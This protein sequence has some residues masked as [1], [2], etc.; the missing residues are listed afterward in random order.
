MPLKGEGWSSWCNGC[1]GR[2]WGDKI[3]VPEGAGS[4]GVMLWG[5]ALG[6][7]EEKDQ[8]PFRPYAQAGSLLE[9]AIRLAGFTRQQFTL[10][11]AIM[12]RPPGNKL[13][14]QP[15]EHEVTERCLHYNGRLVG[16][17]KPR[18]ILALGAVATRLLTEFDGSTKQRSISTVRGWAV[19]SRQFDR[20]GSTL[21]FMGDSDPMPVIPTLH[22]SYIQ[23][24]AKSLL[25][26]L[27]HD[28]R[29][30]VHIARQGVGVPAPTT[31]LLNPS[32]ED[33][34]S[35][36]QE[37]KSNPTRL[38]SYDIET[39]WSQSHE[40]DDD[41]E[42]GDSA[43]TT[44][45]FSLGAH[46]G[47]ELPWAGRYIEIASEI[48][49]TP[50]PKL[51][52]N[53]WQYDE[54]RL[55]SQGCNIRGVHHDLRWAFH[56]LYPDIPTNLQFICSFLSTQMRVLTVNS[57]NRDAAA[58]RPWKHTSQM[59]GTDYGCRDVDMP[60]R[61]FALVEAELKRLGA[62]RSYEEHT[63][64]F[65]PILVRASDYGVPVNP[66]LHA[67]FD[68]SLKAELAIK[69]AELQGLVPDELKMIEPKQGYKNPK[70]ALKR[71]A[72]DNQG[73]AEGERWIEREFTDDKRRRKAARGTEGESG[74]DDL[75]TLYGETDG[76]NGGDDST[77]RTAGAGSNGG[78]AGGR[79][80]RWCRLQPFLPDSP[81][82]VVK[83][84]RHLGDRVP[85]ADD[86]ERDT[87][88]KAGLERLAQKTRRP[89][90]RLILECRALAEMRGT[91]VEGWRPQ[92]EVRLLQTDG[93]EDASGN[94]T[95][96][97]ES[98]QS[99]RSGDGWTECP[100]DAHSH[101][102]DRV[103]PQFTFTPATGQLACYGSPNAL[104]PPKPK[105]K[106]EKDRL[107]VSFRRMIE[108]RPG[109][110][111]W[112][113]DLKSA[114]ALTLGFEAEC[115][116]YMRLARI[117][118]HS[119]LAAHLE[120]V[121]DVKDCLAWP[122]DQL[123]EFLADIKHRYKSTR[124]D[125]A[126]PSILGLGF[127][128]G[129]RKLYRMNRD[130]F[131]GEAD[132]KRV[133]EMIQSLFPRIFQWQDEI[134]R[135]AHHQ[136]FLLSRHGAIRWFQDVYHH[137]AR[138]DRIV[139]GDNSE[140]AIAFLPSNDAFG[141]LKDVMLKL[142]RPDCAECGHA[143]RYHDD[144]YGCEV[145][146]GDAYRNGV[147]QA[148]GPC[149]CKE[150]QPDSWLAKCGLMIPLHDALVMEMPRELEDEAVPLI[151]N[152]IIEPSPVL[153]GLWIGASVSCGSNWAQMEDIDIC[154]SAKQALTQ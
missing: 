10:T 117:D 93:C 4:T 63:L 127:G 67:E 87:T 38:L 50:N 102:S 45:Q 132:A 103:R 21:T 15:Y 40:E 100:L 74:Q 32:I 143:A 78:S 94:G 30:A 14:G 84:I 135:L 151:Y 83:L 58:E 86:G 70:L 31:Y 26:V 69:M 140:A 57:Y 59:Q 3:A 51:G 154:K 152:A 124:D 49:A 39:P 47:I 81:Q 130:S 5:E 147:L 90:Y 56:C 146:R 92:E 134:R 136:G 80:V 115:P 42:S 33:A 76:A 66:V 60:L 53:N 153:D 119:Y 6:E 1:A 8:L 82:Q 107:A 37:V 113:M 133:R 54:P 79:V 85:K 105:G 109:Y 41:P 73:L 108:A 123:S 23:R 141:Y 89:V 48:L 11:N 129:Y 71:M 122:D 145:E 52:C 139:G 88:G 72:L 65:R 126:K 121:P 112:E 77:D 43:I 125:R 9:R 36:L 104:N 97:H 28:I 55:R 111:L 75:G 148:M 142:D 16:R 120:Q 64:R 144:P 110:R 106:A 68:E 22:P 114:H 118:V 19:P 137:D 44:I 13:D 128:M 98:N 20:H 101:S 27:V 91:H 116:E 62:W 35:F 61:A 99:T 25:P 29:L 138:R 17:R 131:T 34:L 24:G 150:P 46:R 18:V 7:H 12:C 149:G 2:Y 95:A 96:L